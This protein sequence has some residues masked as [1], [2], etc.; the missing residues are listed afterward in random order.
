MHN[1]VNGAYNSFISI[2]SRSYE[3][4]FPL[5]KLSN[6]G[7]K[8]RA[9]I[10]RGLK[11]SSAVK[12]K[13]Y[14]KW[15]E[16]KMPSDELKYRNY[17][18]I[19]QKTLKEREKNYYQ[20]KFSIKTNKIKDVWRE[21]NQVCSFKKR[22]DTHCTISKLIVGNE[23]ITENSQITNKMN[24]YFCKV[25]ETLSE[26]LPKSNIDFKSYLP[27]PV[28]ESIFFDPIHKNEILNIINNLNIKKGP[29][30]DSISPRL[31]YDVA[32]E[33]AAPL[34]YLF[35][36][37]LSS[38][39]VPDRLKIANVI[40]IYKKGS[41]FT[42]SNYRPISLLNIFNKVLEKIIYKKLYLFLNTKHKIISPYQFGFRQG[43][44]TTMSLIA[45]MDKIYEQLDEGNIALGIYLDIQKAFDC[46]NHS[47]LLHKLNNYG[48]RGIPLQWIENY[49][50][51]RKQ[52]V[53]V[54][55]TKSGMMNISYG[56][57]HAVA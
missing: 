18:K 13:L 6:R 17:K 36:F 49:L 52:F 54:N 50:T 9:W 20:E 53:Y 37:S 10:T 19:F 35:N 33:I 30:E 25:G 26:S 56:V 15:I 32:A 16:S 31:I 40:P 43:H 24:E 28:N 44:S 34:E 21:I 46:V 48:I 45:V 22:K 4:C 11:I 27:R 5:V 23:I 41:K 38:G 42:P 29:G 57:P 51:D 1:D 55:E 7:N 14:K 2:F 3:K 8:D 12:N 47:I 39:V